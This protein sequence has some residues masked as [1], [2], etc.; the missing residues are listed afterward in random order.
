MNQ[1]LTTNEQ[2]ERLV[3]AFYYLADENTDS[4]YDEFREYYNGIM[5]MVSHKYFGWTSGITAEGYENVVKAYD[6]L[7][8]LG[9][10]KDITDD[11]IDYIVKMFSQK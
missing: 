9:F 1:R 3:L 5:L 2:A 8:D 10:S 4:K 6:I 11:E 7:D